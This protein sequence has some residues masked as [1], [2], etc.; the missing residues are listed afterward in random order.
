MSVVAQSDARMEFWLPSALKTEIEHAA[1]ATHRS[2]T[3]FAT[4]ALR[5]AAQRALAE[6]E[7]HI[8]LS[9]RDWERF[10]DLLDNPPAPNAALKQA[11]ERHRQYMG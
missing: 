1:A 2:L 11:F 5:E 7:A 10:I 9:Q 4:T 8:T 6:Q 3:D